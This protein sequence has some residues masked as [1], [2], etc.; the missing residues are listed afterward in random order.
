MATVAALLSK[1]R[2]DNG[3]A[4]EPYLWTDAEFYDYLDEA[5]D[6]FC[7]LVDVIADD[8]TVTYVAATVAANDG[9]LSIPNYF[10]RI[11][12]AEVLG[13]R[14]YLAL[15]NQEEFEN[16]PNQFA[17]DDYGWDTVSSDWKD[18]TATDPRVLITDMKT[19]SWRLYPIPTEDG[20]IQTRVYRKAILA[21]SASEA[22]EI[23][24]R[25]MQRLLL[26]KV[27]SLSYLKQDSETY[28]L[29]QSQE[30]DQLFRRRSSDFAQRERRSHRRTNVTSYGGIP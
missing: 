24:D 12:S 4:V 23:D 10:T 16:N 13:S 25:Q 27:R 20:T 2:L 1:F 7:E 18:T 5:Q 15:T 11:R 21:P 28:D 19:N 26:V 17:G 14:Q 29:R 30:L 9:Y 6:E 8:V 3:D 22:L